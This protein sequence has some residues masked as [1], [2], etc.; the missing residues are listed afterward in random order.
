MF[1]IDGS[2]LTGGTL[3]EHSSPRQNPPSVVI[4]PVDMKDLFAFDTK[5]SE[6]C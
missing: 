2:C 3:D 6:E 4:I 1:K 5:N